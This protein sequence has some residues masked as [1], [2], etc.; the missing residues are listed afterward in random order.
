[1]SIAKDIDR[2]MAVE[3]TAFIDVLD[4]MINYGVTDGPGLYPYF[5]R[6]NNLHEGSEFYAGFEYDKKLKSGSE[7]YDD[8]YDPT[9]RDWYIEANQNG[10]DVT[11]VSDPYI[12]ADSGKMVVTL[13]RLF[14]T[15]PAKES[16]SY[17]SGRG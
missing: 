1:M 3:Q 17:I 8:N 6:K 10:D 13:S 14:V 11:T 2:W 7:W 9:T 12:D 16:L 15:I 5:E 4:G